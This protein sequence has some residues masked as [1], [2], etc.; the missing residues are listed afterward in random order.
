MLAALAGTTAAAQGPL[1][2]ITIPDRLTETTGTHSL[3]VRRN[4]AWGAASNDTLR[5]RLWTVDGSAKGGTACVNGG[6][7]DYITITDLRVTLIGT[8]AAQVPVVLCHD[9]VF[10]GVEAFRLLA[11]RTDGGP[12]LGGRGVPITDSDPAPAIELRPRFG[13]SPLSWRT[14][15]AE[16]AP[17]A[18]SSQQRLTVGLSVDGAAHPFARDIPVTVRL[19]PGDPKAGATIG[20][21]C[22][23]AGTDAVLLSP[24][25]L[26]IPASTSPAWATWGGHEIE[27]QL[28]DDG[29]YEGDA[30]WLRLRLD[31]PAGLYDEPSSRL[32]VHVAL[33]DALQPPEVVVGQAEVRYAPASGGGMALQP[34]LFVPISLVGASPQYPVTFTYRTIDGTA[35]GGSACLAQGGQATGAHYL[36]RGPSPLEMR[37]PTVLVAVPLCE[38]ELAASRTLQL[39]LSDI[40]FSP[41]SL[42]RG[43]LTH[44][45]QIP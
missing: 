3:T 10:E 25:Q 39:R 42:P 7:V 21:A 38:R 6:S 16:P 14:E 12:E 26:V 24:S 15:A 17:G 34:W 9:R 33:R 5:L 4:P 29:L 31:I 28:C 18:P 2:T 45:I 44:T 35:V 32:S 23:T 1:V 41:T 22:T 40:R 20:T 19:E 30:E 11:A 36:T 8:A 13:P 27:L 37:P 43:P